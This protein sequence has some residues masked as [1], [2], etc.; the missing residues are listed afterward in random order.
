LNPSD[1]ANEEEYFDRI[2][3]IQ[4]LANTQIA[5]IQEQM[6]NAFANNNYLLDNV[7]GKAADIMKDLTTSYDNTLLAMLTGS[8]SIGSLAALSV[9]NID[10]LVD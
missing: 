7:S 8:D 6:E 1:F 10:I 2:K 3:E 5:F 4:D 9:D